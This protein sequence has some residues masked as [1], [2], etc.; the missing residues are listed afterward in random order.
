VPE[1]R[2]GEWDMCRNAQYTRTW[3]KEIHGF[4]SER[5]RIEPEYAM[6]VD[7]SLGF[8]ASARADDG[9]RKGLEQVAP[10]ESGVLG[11]EERARNR[12]RPI[13]L[14]AAMI[15]KQRAWR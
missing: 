1:L 4:M 8:S 11:A 6:R 13:G 12:R 7:R 2:V 3:I 10:W 15:G 9:R 14:L 5:W